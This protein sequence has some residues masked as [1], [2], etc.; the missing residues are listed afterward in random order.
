MCKVNLGIMYLDH[1]IAGTSVQYLF[2]WCAFKKETHPTHDHP[3]PLK[4]LASLRDYCYIC[5]EWNQSP[6]SPVLGRQANWY[7][8]FFGWGGG[9]NTPW[10]VGREGW[11]FAIG[12]VSCRQHVSSN[13]HITFPAINIHY[14]DIPAS[15]L[16]PLV[17]SPSSCGV[18]SKYFIVPRPEAGL[19][20]SPLL[21]EIYF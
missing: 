5:K 3:E 10:K 6:L 20:F 18:R 13:F 12:S 4:S 16:Q 7:A 15:A 2:I 17:N 14:A 19:L 11:V 8:W 9:E 21:T 1:I